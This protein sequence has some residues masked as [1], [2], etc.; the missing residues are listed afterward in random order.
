MTSA[1]VRGLS[2]LA[3]TLI[4]LAVLFTVLSLAAVPFGGTGIPAVDGTADEAYD[5]IEDL[6]A[7][8]SAA[9][10]DG[11]DG[12]DEAV[13][14]ADRSESVAGN[15]SAA[16]AN[17]SGSNPTIDRA[18]TERYIHEFINAE[19]TERGLEPLAS[20]AELREVARYYSA[21]M[22]R[23][24]FF[25]HTAPDGGT[26]SDRYDRFDYDCRVPVENGR[27][28]TGGEN[29]A[30]TFYRTPVRAD[31]GVELYDSERELAR[32][33]VDGWMNS[34]GHRKN[35]LRPYW[36]HEG[37]GVYAIEEGG[38]LRVYATQHFC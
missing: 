5:A 1:V 25:A 12:T 3:T 10:S 36:A 7:D 24:D 11:T 29:L 21:R 23:E 34:T 35:L 18:A 28:A 15:V 14:E 6:S 4:R 13:G 20:D 16:D 30:Y 8:L 26:L 17:A 31:G 37:I 9:L 2:S 38:R 22:A 27:V 32:G 33:I 19:R